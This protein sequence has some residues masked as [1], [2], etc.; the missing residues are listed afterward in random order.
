MA[1]TQASVVALSDIK[2][3]IPADTGMCPYVLDGPPLTWVN[4]QASPLHLSLILASNLSEVPKYSNA[5]TRQ[6]LVVD[7][8]GTAA[9]FAFF[10]VPAPPA[11]VVSGAPLPLRLTWGD[12]L[13]DPKDRRRCDHCLLLE[14]IP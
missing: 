5:S 12:C 6:N 7:V 1:L 11:L 14:P 3:V 2:V 4:L 10:T 13:V 9:V 8:V